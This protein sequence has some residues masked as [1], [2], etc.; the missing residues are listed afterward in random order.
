VI[1]GLNQDQ[2]RAHT[3]SKNAKSFWAKYLHRNFQFF[4]FSRVLSLYQAL[5]QEKND[6]LEK[7]CLQ[8][9]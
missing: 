7:V 2:E 9:L 6:Y 5:Y 8:D 3:L 4:Y 1:H